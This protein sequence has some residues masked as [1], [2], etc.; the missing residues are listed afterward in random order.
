MNP[1]AAPYFFA[2]LAISSAERARLSRRTF[3]SQPRNVLPG[4]FPIRSGAVVVTGSRD[5]S[6]DSDSA[7][8]FPSTHSVR[9]PPCLRAA[10]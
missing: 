7:T 10:T 1:G 3:A 2:S 8:C 9:V 6:N 4:P 5:A